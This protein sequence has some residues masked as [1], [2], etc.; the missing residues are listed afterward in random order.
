MRAVVFSGAKIKDYGFCTEYI[1]DSLIICCDSGV[2]HAYKLGLTPTTI[3]GDLDSATDETLEYFRA[4]DVKIIKY[5]THKDET[6]TQLGLE[7]AINK[8]ATHITIIGGIGNRLDHTLANCQLLLQLVKKGITAEIVN[9]NNYITLIKDKVTLKGAVGDLVSTLPLSMAV[10]GITT[11]GLEYP[12]NNATL[13]M[14]GSLIAVSNVMVEEIAEISISD[15]FL[16]VMK[17]SD[18]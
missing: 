10:S 8:G 7:E 9:E 11:K 4:K 13:L 3:V 12:L 5:P 16:Y 6:D 15:G 17:C 1:K 2:E 18:L 14:E